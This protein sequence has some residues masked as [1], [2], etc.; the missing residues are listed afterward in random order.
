MSILHCTLC[1]PFWV[2]GMLMLFKLC[3]IDIK[4]A[5]SCCRVLELWTSLGSSK[6]FTPKES[7]SLQYWGTVHSKPEVRQHLVSNLVGGNLCQVLGWRSIWKSKFETLLLDTNTCASHLSEEQRWDN[8]MGAASHW[9][10]FYRFL[11][12]R[13]KAIL[14]H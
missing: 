5:F 7:I 1:V 2:V 9:V 12:V 10:R 8:P 13:A 4:C 11:S 6:G 3:L 14:A